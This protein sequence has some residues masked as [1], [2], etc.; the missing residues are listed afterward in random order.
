MPRVAAVVTV[1]DEAPS[2]V[3]QTIASLRAQTVVP[4]PIVLI[5]DGSF[6]PLEPP[7]LP[8]ISHR[9]EPSAGIAA[10]RNHGYRLTDCELIWFV[11]CQVCPDSKWL[12]IAT[13][14]I[15]S[16]NH[17]GL[18]GG[19]HT[20]LRPSSAQ[21]RPWHHRI[22]EGMPDRAT[23]D[24]PWITGHSLLVRRDAL[25]E[26]GGFDEALRIAQEDVDLASRLRAAEWRVRFEPRL[27]VTLTE[28]GDFATRARRNLRHLG[29]WFDCDTAPQ[30]GYRRVDLWRTTRDCIRSC[31]GH[32]VVNLRSRR[33]RNALVDL[34][35]LAF[36][37]REI[38]RFMVRCH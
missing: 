27:S 1:R 32:V 15:A 3:R 17:I 21:W 12:E 14:V 35:V 10:A 34:G 29:W 23:D 38:G 4:C 26:I 37:L 33:V 11:N 5:D 22:V 13:A 30:P 20:Y 9:L 19:S 6:P 2:D 25:E 24:L 8:L 31:K 28:V 18:V 7:E 36:Q 16:D